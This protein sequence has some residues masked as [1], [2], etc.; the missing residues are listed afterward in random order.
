M[1]CVSMGLVYS[2][3]KVSEAYSSSTGDPEKVDPALNELFGDTPPAGAE[4]ASL[5]A[6][7]AS[8]E[9]GLDGV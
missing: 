4:F 7:D 8:D 1:L 3:S 5:G 6:S 2:H 9:I